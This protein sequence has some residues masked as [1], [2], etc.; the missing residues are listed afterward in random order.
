[1]KLLL[2]ATYL[3]LTVAG[4][5]FIKLG[6]NPGSFA[7]KE[8]TVTFGMSIISGIG[9]A[10]YIISF[11]L[12]TR[13]VSDFSNLS[14]IYPILT[15]CVQILTVIASSFVLKEKISIPTIIGIAVIL[16]GIFIMNIKQPQT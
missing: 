7:L 14:Y 10:C 8:G 16:I 12:F 3:I 2:V 15:G 6:G 11:I 1:M 9:F 5:V 13:I 4:V